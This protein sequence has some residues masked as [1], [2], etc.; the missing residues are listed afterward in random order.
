MWSH[1]PGGTAV[2]N[3]DNQGHAIVDPRAA[4]RGPYTEFC[5]FMIVMHGPVKL[6]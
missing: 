3:V 4:D 6:A 2:T 5:T 1:K